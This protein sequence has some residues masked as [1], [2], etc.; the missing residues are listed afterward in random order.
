M[1]LTTV[2]EKRHDGGASS[3]NT[4]GLAW[5]V[6]RLLVDVNEYNQAQHLSKIFQLKEAL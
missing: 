3:E 2:I 5:R 1:S 4:M 6:N